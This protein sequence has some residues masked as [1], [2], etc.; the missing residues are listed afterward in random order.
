M[1]A[2]PLDRPLQELE[3]QRITR[4]CIARIVQMLDLRPPKRRLR[5]CWPYAPK[6]RAGNQ[7]ARSY[8]EA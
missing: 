3:Q 6:F 4:L 1:L 5:E 2:I 7:L 8:I